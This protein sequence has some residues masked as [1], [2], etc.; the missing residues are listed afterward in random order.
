MIH[1]VATPQVVQAISQVAGGSVAGFR[2]RSPGDT[3]LEMC[4]K[5]HRMQCL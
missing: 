5:R 4:L 2:S 3:R 1:H